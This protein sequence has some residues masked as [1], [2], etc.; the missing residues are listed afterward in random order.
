MREHLRHCLAGVRIGGQRGDLDVRMAGGEADEIGARIADAPRTPIL[1][2]FI[3]NT[4]G[5]RS[6]V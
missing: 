1:I 2:L 4:R 6:A 3:A 5:M